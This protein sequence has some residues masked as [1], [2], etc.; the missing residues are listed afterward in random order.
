[1]LKSSLTHKRKR[2]VVTNILLIGAF[3]MS[4][5]RLSSPINHY[6]KATID[7]KPYLLVSQ[8]HVSANVFRVAIMRGHALEFDLSSFLSSLAYTE[9]V[10][11]PSYSFLCQHKLQQAL[12]A[13][14][15]RYRDV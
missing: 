10:G 14:F 1:M 4:I 6:L 15:T 9:T 7:S 5:D 13:S 12:D 2:G 8:S 11:C 3:I